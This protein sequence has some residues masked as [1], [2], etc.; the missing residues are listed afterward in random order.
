M[1]LSIT[2][3]YYTV[4]MD[5]N[6]FHAK[7]NCK[8]IEIFKELNI[9]KKNAINFDII[10]SIVSFFVHFYLFNLCFS[11]TY[12]EYIWY[13]IICFFALLYR[14]KIN[15]QSNQNINSLNSIV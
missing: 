6:K 9:K 11:N 15:R 7:I 8:M 10:R 4:A 5:L 3:K 1:S 12:C 13:L 14:K 2:Y